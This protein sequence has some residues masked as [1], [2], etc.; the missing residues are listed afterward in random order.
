MATKFYLSTENFAPT[1]G[2]RSA[3]D[4]WTKTATS[5]SAF[6]NKYLEVLGCR[7]PPNFTSTEEAMGSEQSES[8]EEALVATA[9]EQSPSVAA[10]EEDEPG[11]TRGVA[12]EI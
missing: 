2:T 10:G 4:C 12:T 5:S 11:T 7:T 6:L 8:N 3:G 9:T 1:L